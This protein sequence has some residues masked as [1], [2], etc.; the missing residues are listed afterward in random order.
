MEFILEGLHQSRM[1]GK[2][3]ADGQINYY[4]A[5]GDMMQDIEERL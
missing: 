1:V 2:D 5:L 4:D 3:D